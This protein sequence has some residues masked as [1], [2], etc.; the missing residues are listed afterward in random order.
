MTQ[1][2]LFSTFRSLKWQSSRT[3]LVVSGLAALAV[4]FACTGDSKA[5]DKP[6]YEFKDGTGPNGAM[7]VINGK[8]LSEDEFYGDE[9]GDFMDVLNKVHEMRVNRVGRVLVEQVYGEEAKKAGLSL[10]Q[11]VETKVI[12]L[13]TKVS[14]KEIKKLA[15]ENK[16]AADKIDQF[17]DQIVNY[18]LNERRMKE[19]SKLV[20][21][22]SATNKVE[23]YFK[24]P[25]L[26]VAVEAGN[27]PF[28]G[29]ADAKVTIVE[30]SDFQCPYCAKGAEVM[31]KVRDQYG[32]KVKIAFKHYPLPMHP[33]A[34]PAAEASMCVHDQSPEKFWKYHDLL[35]AN[36]KDLGAEALK[37]YAKKV[38]VKMEDFTKCVESKK[39]AATVAA[40]MEYGQK[41]GVRSTPMF[42]VNGRLV[43]GAQPL[44]AF[45]SVI[46][47]ELGE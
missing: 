6:K 46:D 34:M 4:V 38:G 25:N 2:K 22:L 39:H 7:A 12:K 40:D 1:N 36:A 31:K 15:E 32:K 44:E 3:A 47:E 16:L 33:D 45:Q 5:K 9:K 30:F 23:L 20:A 41:Y 17:K 21:K 13:D 11:Y 18:I 42:F 19:M 8:A 24:R 27:A 29:G 43:Q 10:D 37:N 28:T 26:R 35:F 14:D